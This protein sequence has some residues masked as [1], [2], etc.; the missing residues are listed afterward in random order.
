MAE[1]GSGNWIESIDLA[2]DETEVPDQEVAGEIAEPGRG[3][4]KAPRRSKLAAVDQGAKQVSI[5]VKT[6][7]APFPSEAAICAARPDS[8]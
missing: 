8:A 5:L 1:K 7:T 3:K 2:G 4:S 6:A